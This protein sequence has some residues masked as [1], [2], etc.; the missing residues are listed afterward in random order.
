MNVI[1]IDIIKDILITQFAYANKRAKGEN[2]IK[3][4]I[5]KIATPSLIVF[6]LRNG[7][8]DHY[9]CEAFQEIYNASFTEFSKIDILFK[10]HDYQIPA[11]L[12]GLLSSN[13]IKY[14]RDT[15]G[16]I[17]S[18]FKQNKHHLKL[19]CVNKNILFISEMD[20]DMKNVLNFVNTKKSTSAEE[21]FLNKIVESI[22]KLGHILESL[23]ERRFIY[24]EGNQYFS[25]YHF[26]N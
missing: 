10:L 7:T 22:E 26:I 16:D 23:Q 24:K 8:I 17:Y 12:R 2:Y 18:F 25:I 4:T 3:E 5:L 19:I 15:Q 11:L 6:N 13:S 20:Q 1:E 21:I 14:S 9:F